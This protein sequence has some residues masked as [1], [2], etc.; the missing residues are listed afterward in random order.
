M[1]TSRTDDVLASGARPQVALTVGFQRALLGA[2]VFIVAAAVI[3]LRATN[4]RGEIP[5]DVPTEAPE[6]ETE[7]ETPETNV[8]EPA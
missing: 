8:V 3:A 2:A 1:A 6:P 5:R 7:T 4:T